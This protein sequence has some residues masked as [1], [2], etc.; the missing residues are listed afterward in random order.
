[1]S[2]LPPLPILYWS[3]SLACHPDVDMLAGVIDATNAAMLW[4]VRDGSTAL[5]SELPADAVPLM[6]DAAVGALVQRQ[7]PTLPDAR[8]G[9][10]WCPSCSRMAGTNRLSTAGGDVC[11]TCGTRLVARPEEVAR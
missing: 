8:T 2:T 6:L 10:D 5:L 1:M 7:R 4:H 9:L 11:G 3:E